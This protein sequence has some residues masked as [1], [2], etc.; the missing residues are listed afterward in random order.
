MPRHAPSPFTS[1]LFG[2]TPAKLPHEERLG[3]QALLGPKHHSK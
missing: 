1:D 3:A 2:E